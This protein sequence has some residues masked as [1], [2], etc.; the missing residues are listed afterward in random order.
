MRYVAAERVLERWKCSYGISRK[1]MQGGLGMSRRHTRATW[2][3]WGLT[4]VSATPGQNSMATPGASEYTKNIGQM[5]LDKL[6]HD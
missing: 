3:G 1:G 5:L 6:L 2:Q 4:G